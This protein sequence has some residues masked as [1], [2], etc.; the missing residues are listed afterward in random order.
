MHI[1]DSRVGRCKSS[2][3][4]HATV[5]Q[6]GRLEGK[7]SAVQLLRAEKMQIQYECCGFQLIYQN[8]YG[9]IVRLA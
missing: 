8:M 7:P 5:I 3:R 6:K 4:G 2:S 9:L 1:T